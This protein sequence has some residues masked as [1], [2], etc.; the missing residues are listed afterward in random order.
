MGSIAYFDCFSGVAGDM[1]L[2]ALVDAGLPLAKLTRELERLPLSGYRLVRDRTRRDVRGV[3]LHVEVQREP[4]HSGYTDLD[5]MI[6]RSRL[7]KPVIEM[8]RAILERLAKAE[9][10]VH[11]VRLD[12]V[13]FHEV[14]A[15]DS[16]VDIVGSAIGFHHFGFSAVHASPLPMNR[17]QVRCAHGQMPV[18]AP[19]TM[20]LMKGVPLEPTKVREEIVTPTGAAI[21]ATVAE[22]FGE[23]PLQVVKK[24]GYGYG[25]KVI[26]GLP[27]ALRLMIG[28]GF[29]VLCVQ[30][31]IDDMNP[32]L[33]DG[34]LDAL[35]AAGAVDVDLAAVQMKKNRPGIKLSALVPWEHKDAVI[36]VFLRETSTFGVRY[37]PAERKVLT[38]TIETR[39]VHKGKVRFKLGFDADGTCLKAVPEYADVK[40]LAQKS[41]RPLIDLYHEAFAEGRKLIRS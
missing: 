40:K 30:A 16:L 32:E 41:K 11:G 29:P 26:P 34:V 13:H 19:A 8:A 7:Q 9:A 33:Y 10:R 35:F 4:K 6:A 17:G 14:G 5:A 28:E 37:W 38:R 31:T 27:N 24:V 22:Q 20:E 21:L 15:V 25:D 1:I 36:A 2:G 23:C 39:T 12:R 3:N 18:P